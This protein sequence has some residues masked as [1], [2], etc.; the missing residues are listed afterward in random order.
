MNW[1]CMA[2]VGYPNS[3]MVYFMDNPSIYDD[4]GYPHGHGN[5]QNLE[6]AVPVCRLNWKRLKRSVR[7]K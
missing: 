1:V 3:W 5:L 7:N 4:W 6:I 2:M